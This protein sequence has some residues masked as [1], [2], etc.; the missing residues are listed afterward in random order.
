MKS[1]FTGGE[2]IRQSY[3]ED[4][5]FRGEVIT[6]DYNN[7]LCKDTGETFTDRYVDE[8]NLKQLYNGYR[9]KHNIPFPEEIKNIRQRYGT[10][11]NKMSAILGFGQN[12]YRNY[13]NG[14]VPSLANAKLITLI[15]EPDE[16][17][18]LLKNCD[19]ISSK[20]KKK[21]IG[22]AEEF[23]QQREGEANRLFRFQRPCPA[24]GYRVP[25]LKRLGA[26]INIFAK[27]LEPFKVKLSKLLFYADFLHFKN[28]GESISGNSYQAI[29]L[30]P[31]PHRYGTLFENG[32]E[33]G[34]YSLE[35]VLFEE[36]EGEK[37]KPS[38]ME[39]LEGELN[40]QEIETLRIVKEQLGRK[41]TKELVELSHDELGWQENEKEQGIIDYSYAF[42]LKQFIE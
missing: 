21:Y 6:I 27:Q 37:F 34:Y 23:I 4:L 11:Q 7:Y 38:T 22:K 35:Q 25:S 31:V 14:D 29:G 19:E 1:P 39:E 26:M 5:T 18:K 42:K 32:A 33:S 8:L 20:D 17:I 24:T 28:Y 15:E 13:E 40:K 30:G 36:H 16:F 2:V 3:K 12:T 10:S 9:L 41:S